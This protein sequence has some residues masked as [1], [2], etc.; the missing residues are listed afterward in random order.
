MRTPHVSL[1]VP[2]HNEEEALPT[3]HREIVDVMAQTDLR[4]ELLL[5]DDGSRDQTAARIAELAATDARVR[6]VGFSRNFGK[7]AAML[8][9]LRYARGEAVVIMDADLQHPPALVPQLVARLHRGDVD[10]VVARRTRAGDS[11][12]RTKLAGVYYRWVNR[13]VDDVELENGTG[14]FRILSRRAVNVLTQ[15]DERSRFSKGL[16]S[17]I[18]FPTAAIDYDNRLRDTGKSSW[19]MRSLLNYGLDGIL[20]FNTKPLRVAA[21]T[22]LAAVALAVLYVL[23]LIG[24]WAINGVAVPGYITLI[25]AIVGF[26]GLQ[27]LALGLIGEYVGRIYQEVKA[28]PHYVVAQVWETHAEDQ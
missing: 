26:S 25:A 16:F 4:W 24:D 21:V 11:W 9:G 12:A 15:M 1:V 19:T 8:A 23:F 5:I 10:Q 18:G 2:C 6:G 14:D 28:R 22:G 27:L 3:L 20:S 7:E 13:L 17:W